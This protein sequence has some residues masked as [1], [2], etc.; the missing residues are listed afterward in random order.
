MTEMSEEEWAEL[1]EEVKKAK[2]PHA[3]HLSWETDK[4]VAESGV[5]R[6]FEDEL[7]ADG[8]DFFGKVNQRCR[9]D[10]PPDFGALSYTG[11][12]IGLE[13]TELVD[14]ASA[15]A[16]RDGIKYD[17]KD[18]RND[19]I[20]ELHKIIQKKDE[21]NVKGGPYTEYVLLIYSSE[22]WLEIDRI[23]LDITAHVFAA[24]N[25]ITRAYFLLPYDPSTQRYPCFRLMIEGAEI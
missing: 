6:Q 18:W 1:A 17:W 10:D 12:R 23:R 8:R 22:Y 13:V 19:L 5:L 3:G 11:E 16:A 24:T 4:Q 7:K 15:A 25:Q 2:R 14:P 21:A 9:G 20:P